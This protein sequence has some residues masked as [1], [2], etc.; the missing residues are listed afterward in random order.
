M[1]PTLAVFLAGSL[2]LISSSSTPLL[3]Y[4]ELYVVREG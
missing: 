2:D 3:E 1:N 4:W